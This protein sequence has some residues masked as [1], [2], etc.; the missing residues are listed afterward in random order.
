MTTLTRELKNESS[1]VYQWFN[2]KHN[3]G[4]DHLIAH[5]NNVLSPRNAIA[6]NHYPQ[7]FD[8]ALAGT[9]FIYDMLP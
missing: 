7:G 6:L 2:T 4:G 1:P 5:H 3:K 9:A 8:Y